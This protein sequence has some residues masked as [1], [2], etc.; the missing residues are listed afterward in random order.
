[1]RVSLVAGQAGGVGNACQQ[2]G[3]GG[4]VVD[5]RNFEQEL[6]EGDVLLVVHNEP[7]LLYIAESVS[8]FI[9]I[10]LSNSQVE[11]ALA[12]RLQHLQ[13]HCEALEAFEGLTE[14]RNMAAALLRIIGEIL[15][16]E[17]QVEA[18]RQERGL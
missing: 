18:S 15:L 16:I 10:S 5:A 9:L 12:L 17:T 1:M 14:Q 13:L 8:L 11:I 4:I 2:G 6:G 7:L 3:T